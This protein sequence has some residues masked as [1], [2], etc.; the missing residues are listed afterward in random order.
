MNLLVVLFI[1]KLSDRLYA[2]YKT[3]LKVHARNHL[4]VD[5]RTKHV[6]KATSSVI[7]VLYIH[8]IASRSISNP[9]S[10]FNKSNY[11]SFFIAK[12]QNSENEWVFGVNVLCDFV[13]AIGIWI[14]YVSAFISIGFISTNGA[15]ECFSTKCCHSNH[16]SIECD[17]RCSRGSYANITRF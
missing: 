7:S 1:Q 14:Q 11:F 8:P 4:K 13:I 12:F 5:P 9:I 2:K 6:D 15:S 17:T 16:E 10:G 3:Q